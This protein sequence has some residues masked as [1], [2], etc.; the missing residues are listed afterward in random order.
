[1]PFSLRCNDGTAT[2]LSAEEA[3][4]CPVLQRFSAAEAAARPDRS[5]LAVSIP[6]SGNQLLAWRKQAQGCDTN[7]LRSGI[8]IPSGQL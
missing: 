2:T 6:F 1:M 7:A 3:S 5:N 4:L 8:Q